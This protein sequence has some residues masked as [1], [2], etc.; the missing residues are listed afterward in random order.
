MKLVTAFIQFLIADKKLDKIINSQMNYYI[1]IRMI[2]NFKHE[3]K[4]DIY[5]SI[6]N[7]KRHRQRIAIN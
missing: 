1:T 4:H 6:I 2:Q 7:Y 5:Y 3:K